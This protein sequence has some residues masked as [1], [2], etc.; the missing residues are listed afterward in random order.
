MSLIYV[1]PVAGDDADL[2][3]LTDNLIAWY[4]F[5]EDGTTKTA[6][7]S[8]LNFDGTAYTVTRAAGKIGTGL[9]CE[10][11]QANLSVPMLLDEIPSGLKISVE[12]WVKLT[13]A[14]QRGR[15]ATYTLFSKQ[16]DSGMRLYAYFITRLEQVELRLCFTYLN[17]DEDASSVQLTG[18]TLGS[19][20]ANGVY[21]AVSDVRYVHDVRADWTIERNDGDTGWEVRETTYTLDAETGLPVADDEPTVH[22]TLA[23]TSV[24]G[25]WVTTADGY[26]TAETEGVQ[27]REEE[28]VIEAD[29][30][31][32]DVWRKATIILDLRS[33]YLSKF[34]IFYGDA[35]A[36][37]DTDFVVDIPVN[38]TISPERIGGD[39]TAV[40]I[41]TN[42]AS[43]PY[44]V[45][46]FPFASSGRFG[47]A[48]VID[49][50]ACG[51]S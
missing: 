16:W 19:G 34:G 4:R 10:A 27:V 43:I 51:P 31:P 13:E 46:G 40:K 11:G 35:S 1:P 48:A 6:V 39:L 49:G 41:A 42:D 12:M 32:A 22:F 44:V 20:D 38:G 26:G 47:L 8:G 50:C 3:P 37:A 29:N 23:G 24:V 17:S 18:A 15:H 30:F 7:D 25:E 2:E 9:P 45:D 21:H 33:D 28:V 14:I 5:A 36:T